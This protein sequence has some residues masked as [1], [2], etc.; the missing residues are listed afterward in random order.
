MDQ[1]DVACRG[2]LDPHAVDAVLYQSNPKAGA[3]IH[4]QLGWKSVLSRNDDL[5]SSDPKVREW[6][7][8]S[9]PP[10]PSSINTRYNTPY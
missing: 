8:D 6:V 3:S 7:I 9:K 10:T 5:A 1:L 2:S 4:S